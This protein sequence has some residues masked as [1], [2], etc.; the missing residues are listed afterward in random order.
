MN[1]LLE[2]RHPATHH[3]SI[4]LVPTFRPEG[5]TITPKP[6]SRDDADPEGEGSA[7]PKADK[8]EHHAHPIP[9]AA[10]RG[11]NYQAEYVRPFWLFMLI[12]ADGHSV[13]HCS[14]VAR[15]IR[16][17]KLESERCG[18]DE[19]RIVMGIFDEVRKQGR[20]LGG[21]A[22]GKAGTK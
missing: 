2:N 22:K 11:M 19:S 7:N 5:F 9:E 12:H 18:L 6:S 21:N 20:Y 13:P 10:G 4:G 3:L 17:G 8:S 16:D 1:L 15:C 14:E